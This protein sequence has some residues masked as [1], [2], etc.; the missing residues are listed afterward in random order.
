MFS[1]S[2]WVSSDA[3]CWSNRSSRDE[4][5]P[6]WS[7]S[8]RAWSPIRSPKS[9]SILVSLEVRSITILDSPCGFRGCSTLPCRDS[10]VEGSSG[11]S[12]AWSSPVSPGAGGGA[13][14]GDRNRR[15]LLC[16]FW[17]SHSEST[18]ALNILRSF[19][20][21]LSMP[22]WREPKFSTDILSACMSRGA[23]AK[24]Y[25]CT[26]FMLVSSSDTRM[27]TLLAANHER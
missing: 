20:T 10:P 5:L 4:S 14:P 9:R 15:A 8:C 13:G 24:Q 23:V 19:S 7:P 22:V 1:T 12:G 3:I 16:S 25:V 21:D 17:I 2:R 18:L 27:S 26:K 11:S 6:L